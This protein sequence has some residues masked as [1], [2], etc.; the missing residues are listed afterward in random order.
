MRITGGI[1]L[2]AVAGGFLSGC[3]KST[4]ATADSAAAASST[5]SGSFDRNAARAEILGADSAFMRAMM[6]KKVDSLM[7]YYDESV[8][9]MSEG[10]KAVKGLRD[11]RASYVEAMKTNHSVTD[12]KRSREQAR[13][14]PS[15]FQRAPLE[16][17]QQYEEQQS[18][19]NGFIQ[20]G[21]MTRQ[22]LSIRWKDHRPR[23]IRRSA[24]QLAV[25]EISDAPEEESLRS[26]ESE[27]VRNGP[28]RNAIAAGEDDA[29]EPHP[30]H[31]PAEQAIV[32]DLERRRQSHRPGA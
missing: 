11:V 32:A 12:E 14:V 4:P 30:Q 15:S 13:P 24:I 22:M 29:R 1:A 2:L 21:W 7:P 20:L 28:E 25:D 17:P 23:D 26:T 9:S 19:T 10:A 31:R 3:N 5:A 27:G 6:A 8:V 18:F 16:Q